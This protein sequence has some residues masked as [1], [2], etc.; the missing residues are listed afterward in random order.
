MNTPLSIFTYLALKLKL[1][2]MVVILLGNTSTQY[3]V[4]RPIRS[5]FREDIQLLLV[6]ATNR[7]LQKNNQLGVGISP[8]SIKLFFMKWFVV[9]SCQPTCVV[10]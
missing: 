2:D 5:I 10:M 7:I 1:S 9:F 3:F 8:Y 6:S 4:L